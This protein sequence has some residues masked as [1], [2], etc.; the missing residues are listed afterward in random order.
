[1]IARWVPAGPAEL[2]ACRRGLAAALHD[3]A[4][5]PGAD[6]GAVERLLLAY[7][8]LA[9]NAVR[10]GRGPVE[11]TVTSNDTSWLLEVSD[12]AADR[13][14]SPAIGRDP[15]NGGLGLHLVSRL[16]DAHGW[17]TDGHRKTVW[18]RIDH[19]SP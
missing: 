9:S 7:E 17:T 19:T 13:P 2:T 11:V 4:R 8:E 15:A 1:M 5:P 12:A 18:A 14:P 16:C 3:G 10:H 6:E